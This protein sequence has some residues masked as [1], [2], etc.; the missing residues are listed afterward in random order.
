MTNDAARHA[1]QA[2]RPQS[3][4]NVAGSRSFTGPT[5]TDRGGADTS[6]W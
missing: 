4:Q 2:A 5:L 1:L 6:R 3:V